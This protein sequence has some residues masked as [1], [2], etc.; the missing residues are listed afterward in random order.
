MIAAVSGDTFVRLSSTCYMGS[1]S[2]SVKD[3]ISQAKWLV[4]T[5]DYPARGHRAHAAMPQTSYSPGKIR[6]TG[7]NMRTASEEATCSGHGL[8]LGRQ[9]LVRGQTR[10]LVWEHAVAWA[11][12]RCLLCADQSIA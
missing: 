9:I 6:A 7:S 11:G 10:C 1:Q 8:A 5:C 4:P 2:T 12:T 3:G